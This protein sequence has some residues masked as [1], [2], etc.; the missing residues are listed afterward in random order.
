VNIFPNPLKRALREGRPQVGLW[1]SIPSPITIEIVAGSGFDWLTLDTEHSPNDVPTVLNQLHALAESGLPA[2]VRPAWNDPV[3]FKRFMDIG[4]I[5]FVV[6]WVQTAE[7]ARRAVAATR[8][9]PEGIRGVAAAVRA[10]RYGRIT[11]YLSRVH[12]E[13]CLIVQL[14]TR[15]ALGNL[16]AIAAVEGVDALFIGPSD[17]AADLGHLGDNAHPAVRDTIEDAIGRIRR[18]GKAAGILAVVESDA[19][20][21]LERGALFVGIGS[22]I[23]LLARHSEALVARTRDV[24]AALPNRRP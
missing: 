22:D 11:D 18:A 3:L 1:C 10:N 8:Y 7:E 17:L 24:L 16:E 2:V 20:Y 9:A 12:D 4:V 6:P 19:K 5:N 14:E 23:G 21:W 13:I 15:T